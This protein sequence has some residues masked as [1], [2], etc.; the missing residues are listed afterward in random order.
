[1]ALRD[2]LVRRHPQA[3]DKLELVSLHFRMTREIGENRLKEAMKQLQQWSQAASQL[4]RTV[5]VVGPSGERVERVER[6]FDRNEKKLPELLFI[7]QVCFD[8]VFALWP[9]HSGIHSRC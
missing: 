9:S 8:T 4:P 1:M 7:I 5:A 3:V 6:N 2:Y